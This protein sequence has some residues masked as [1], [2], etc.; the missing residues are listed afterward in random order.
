M[1]ET[2]YTG[3]GI[4]VLTLLLM[5]EIRIVLQNRRVPITTVFMVRAFT[6]GSNLLSTVLTLVLVIICYLKWNNCR[7]QDMEC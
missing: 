1:V 2:S 4:A 5:S 3:T 7:R 6:V